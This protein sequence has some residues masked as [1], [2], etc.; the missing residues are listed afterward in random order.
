MPRS[1]NHITKMNTRNQ[2]GQ[3]I[4]LGKL[5]LGIAGWVYCAAGIN[6]LAGNKIP[7]S[8]LFETLEYHYQERRNNTLT[9]RTIDS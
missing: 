7:G 1:T 4:N 8:G 9:G 6:F 3:G 5:D 2:V